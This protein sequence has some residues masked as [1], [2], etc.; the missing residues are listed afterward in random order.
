MRPIVRALVL[1]AT[2]A[3]AAGDQEVYYQVGARRITIADEW[4]GTIVIG[5]RATIEVTHAG[6]VITS[7]TCHD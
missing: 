7:A 3:S 6:I 5:R 4:R 1:A 2:L